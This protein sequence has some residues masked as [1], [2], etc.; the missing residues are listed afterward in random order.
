MDAIT[1]ADALHETAMR[2]ASR[3]LLTAMRK[4]K[5]FTEH[6]PST[7]AALVW[8]AGTPQN[9]WEKT[10]GNYAD[11]R[12]SRSHRVLAA[13]AEKDRVAELRRV[14]RDPCPMCGIRA[15]VGCRHSIR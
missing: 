4:A 11:W 13:L 7:E 14:S 6:K 8:R 5:F 15:D 9:Q 2:D 1:L 12:D 3:S 10:G